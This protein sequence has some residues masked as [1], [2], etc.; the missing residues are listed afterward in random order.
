MKIKKLLATLALGS[1]TFLGASAHA[2]FILDT[3][4]GEAN[5]ANSGDATELAAIE[6]ATGNNNLTLDFKL[7]FTLGDAILNPGTTDQWVLDVAPNTPGYFLLK[8]GTGGTNATANTFFFQNIGELTKLVWSNA[9]VQFLSGGNCRDGND[10]A[11]NIGRLS[12]YNGYND[13]G[14]VVPEP[15]TVSLLGLG[16]LGF[17]VSR[18]RKS[19]R[20]SA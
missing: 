16:L 13:G 3:K 18:R 19:A 10:N 20:K 17:A 11:C 2:A 14:G 5:L 7:D 15:A 4:I 8:F 1:M 12:H 6:A 9:D